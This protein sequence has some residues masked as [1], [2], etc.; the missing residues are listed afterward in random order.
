MRHGTTRRLGALHDTNGLASY[1]IKYYDDTDVT[2][3]DFEW[4]L[5]IT[6]EYINGPV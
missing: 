2:L 5:N 6:S 4:T 3:T 1:L